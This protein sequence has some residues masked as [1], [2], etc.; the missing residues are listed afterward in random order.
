MRE[1]EVQPA[2]GGLPAEACP[3]CPCLSQSSVPGCGGGVLAP[4]LRTRTV[5]GQGQVR[6]P[7]GCEAQAAAEA[8]SPW[9]A[10]EPP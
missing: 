4:Q 1:A 2:R 3:G 10:L 8:R 6:A 7:C 9:S 5:C